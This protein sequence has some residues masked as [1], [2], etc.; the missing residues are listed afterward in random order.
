MK[1]TFSYIT[2]NIITPFGSSSVTFEGS[3]IEGAIAKI[4]NQGYVRLDDGCTYP[5][6]SIQAI[7]S[8]QVFT[9]EVEVPE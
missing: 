2:L 8:H 6:H 1:E 4:R 5:W 9:K 3:Y 7:T